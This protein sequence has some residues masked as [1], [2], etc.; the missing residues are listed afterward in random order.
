M[1]SE[2]I[3][4]NS[5]RFLRTKL[6]IKDG[7]QFWGV[8]K[9]IDF[10]V[11]SDDTYVMIT[12]PNEGMRIDYL[13]YKYLGSYDLWWVLCEAN[14]ITNPFTELTDNSS[15][16]HTSDVFEESDTVE[17]ESTPR[18][19]FSVLSK[20]IGNDWNSGNR[21]GLKVR[22]YSNSLK[23]YINSRLMETFS[24]LSSYKWKPNVL[25]SGEIV[26][27]NEENPNFWG[28]I[29]S[30]YITINWKC[31]DVNR[32]S[33]LTTTK[34]PPVIPGKDVGIDY[35]F[36]GGKSS[37]RKTIRIPSLAHIHEKLYI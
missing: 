36:F 19:C 23:V 35:Y 13:A 24:G 6:Y 4:K 29:Q 20:N 18:L 10:P 30:K 3:L 14:N 16:A 31:L 12:K 32:K 37:L 28:N 27:S 26:D 34:T 1:S 33:K 25:P 15:Y 5:S 11:R 7:E 9:R 22:I 2:I 8:W 21:Y 17:P